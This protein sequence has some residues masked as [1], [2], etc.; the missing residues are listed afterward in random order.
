MAKDID[1]S[2]YTSLR[3]TKKKLEELENK[4]TRKEILRYY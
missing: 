4:E 3:T 1:L 2:K